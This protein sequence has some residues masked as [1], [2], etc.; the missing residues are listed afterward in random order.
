MAIHF[1]T[2][3]GPEKGRTILVQPGK[4][5]MMGRAHDAYYRVNDESVS[6]YHCEVLLEGDHIKVTCNGGDGGTWVNGLK[7]QEYV[8]KMDDV[9]KIGHTRL[10]L[11]EGVG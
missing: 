9:L 2:L 1:L 6:R 5:F 8:L 4:D 7:I 10:Q 3:E 11:K